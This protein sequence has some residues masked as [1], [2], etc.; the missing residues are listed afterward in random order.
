MFNDLLN[1]L[2]ALIGTNFLNL[3]SALAILIIGWI[4][5]RLIAWGAF[6]LLQ[7]INLDNRLAGAI[8]VEDEGTEKAPMSKI[9]GSIVYVLVLIPAVIAALN[10]LQIEAL[11][12][13]S[14]AMLT[15]VLNAIPA[16]FGAVIV[17]AVVYFAGKLVSG[18][19]SNLLKGIGF[20]NLSEKLGFQ[21]ERTEGQRSL[22]D[23]VGL[24]VLVTVMLLA[25]IEASNILGLDILANIIA[26]L[27]AFGGQTLLALIIFGFGLY[28]ANLARSVIISASG[29]NSAFYSQS[30]PYCHIG[31]CRRASLAAI[32]H[33]Q[34]DCQPSVWDFARHDRCSCRTRLWA[35]F[36][37]NRWETN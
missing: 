10:A 17:L 30:S 9:I 18:L 20:D 6:K 15:V 34:R 7:R 16:F 13:P 21:A 23:I 2:L 27:T 29:D 11:S 32:G 26:D 3:L 22:S 28:L 12:A 19:V 24:L 8:A 5:A 31:I 1:Q 33:C 4:V 35:G 37:R 25:S 36:P 14:V